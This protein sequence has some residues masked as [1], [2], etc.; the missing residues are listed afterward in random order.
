MGKTDD[1]ESAHAVWRNRAAAAVR[2]QG[3]EGGSAHAALPADALTRTY[4]G[5]RES[6]EKPLIAVPG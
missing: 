1:G 3:D 2:W 5:Y 6:R 4:V